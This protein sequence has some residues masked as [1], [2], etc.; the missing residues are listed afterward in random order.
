[1]EKKKKRD[2]VG[3]IIKLCIALATIVAVFFGAY[4][5]LDKLIVPKYFKEYG[6]NNMHELVGMVKTLY[7]SPDE[8]D[9]ITN[10]YSAAEQKSA[11]K[12]L[13]QANFPST[14]DNEIDY[15]AISEGFDRKNTL[16]NGEYE[17]SDKEIASIL[18]QMLAS[19]SGVLA[20]KLSHIKYINAVNINILEL[21]I[22]PTMLQDEFGQTYCD[23]NSANASFILKIN[24]TSIRSQM[25]KAMDTPEFLLNM[26]IP[27]ILYISLD[28]NLEKG[29]DGNWICHDSKIGVNGRT[30][31]DSEILLNLIIK[32]VFVPEDEMTIEKLSSDFGN[33]LIMGMDVLGDI[34]VT[35]NQN[36]NSNGIIL[37]IT[38]GQN[39][40]EGLQ[41]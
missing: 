4:F 31:K 21:T 32:F 35:S 7:N 30:E 29:E 26:I 34:Q 36:T 1:M 12:K 11:V 22:T 28:F 6:I 5:A 39:P 23:P 8:K 33:I 20:S 19:E 40:V 17:L 25:A 14:K 37:T 9:M 13:L 3:F 15:F 27:K 24:T 16:I 10:G 18:D 2:K 41:E 38:D